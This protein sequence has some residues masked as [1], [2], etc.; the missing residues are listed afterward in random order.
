MR[1]YRESDASPSRNPWP[2]ILMASTI[3]AGLALDAATRASLSALPDIVFARPVGVVI[4]LTALTIEF[5]CART[6]ARHETTILPHRAARML[7]T[8]GLYRW[9]RNPI[10]LAHLMLVFATG[11][12]FASPFILA[13]TPVLA[14]AILKLAVEAEERHLI[15]RF[16]DDY[17]SYLAQ[18]PRW[19]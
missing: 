15:D 18:T 19:L 2:P 16:G 6:L 12:F 5:C 8:D 13:L 11:L 7:V 10:Y 3:G 9:S 1:F 4:A 14:L 17:R